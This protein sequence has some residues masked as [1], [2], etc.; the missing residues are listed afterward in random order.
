MK[1]PFCLA[2]LDRKAV[3]CTGCNARRG[4]AMFGSAPDSPLVAR[5]KAIGI[6][7]ALLP[8]SAIGYLLRPTTIWLAVAGVAI[9]V[10]VF[11]IA[12][13]RQ[14]SFWYQV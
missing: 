1:C 12:R 2:L 13:L 6:P 5:I 10:A 9:A 3:V 7:A 14:G 4:Y 11:G 8:I